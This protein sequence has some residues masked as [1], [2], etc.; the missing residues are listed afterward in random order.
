MKTFYYI[1]SVVL[2]LV[3]VV[4][5]CLGLISWG[6][7]VTLAILGLT[8]V[9]VGMQAFATNKMAQY[10]LMPSVDV[11]MVYH[12]PSK[13]TYFWFANPSNMPALVSL[14]L[15]NKGNNKE[16]LHEQH[17]R[18]SPQRKMCTSIVYEFN[19]SKD[20]EV[21]LDVIIKCDLRNFDT[22]VEFRKSYRFFEFQP[23]LYQWAETTWGDADPS[24]P[25]R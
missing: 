4:F 21:D 15:T 12:N 23:N 24:W 1:I 10:Q 5:A 19:P 7:A 6:E 20:K 14:R 18:I 3:A 25:G 13:K 9:A 2:I 17:F 22:K 11:N 8:A 16:K